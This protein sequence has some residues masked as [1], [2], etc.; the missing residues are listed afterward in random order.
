MNASEVQ[1]IRLSLQ[2]TVEG[3]SLELK[4]NPDMYNLL[5]DVGRTIV[6]DS[7]LASIAIQDILSDYLA[8]LPKD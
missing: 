7:E 4:L 8:E 5:V 1:A 3:E 6:S 2:S